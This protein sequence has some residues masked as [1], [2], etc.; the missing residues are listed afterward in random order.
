MLTAAARGDVRGLRSALF[1]VASI[2]EMTNP[3]E[4][5]FALE[6]VLYACGALRDWI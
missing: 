5:E 2:E 3:R 6:D 1:E 4:L